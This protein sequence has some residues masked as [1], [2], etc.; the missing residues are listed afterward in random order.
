[1]Q[2]VLIIIIFTYYE[3]RAGKEFNMV[4]INKNTFPDSLSGRMNKEVYYRVV[5]GETY[6]SKMPGKRKKKKYGDWDE[7]NFKFKNA[8]LFARN[9]LQRPERKAIYHAK[10][11]GFNNAYTIAIADYMKNPEITGIS[12]RSYKG[13][14]GAR[15][16][17]SVANVVPVDHVELKILLPDNSILEQGSAIPAK[18]EGVWIYKTTAETSIVKG[19]T[20]RVKVTDIPEHRVTKDFPLL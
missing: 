16:T 10:A 13:R 14:P 9:M 8:T 6:A 12:A 7:G 18:K 20:L 15:L 2:F 19:I 5:N 1:M 11:S 3:S 4:K 17:I